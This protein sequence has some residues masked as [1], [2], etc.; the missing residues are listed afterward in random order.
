MK[1][2]ILVFILLGS[3]FQREAGYAESPISFENITT[4]NGLIQ[5]SVTSILQDKSGFMWIGTTDGLNRYDGKKFIYYKHRNDDTTS[6]TDNFISVLHEDH[7][8]RI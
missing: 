3:I 1:K 5:N 4:A 7:S 8:G 2:A 6:L